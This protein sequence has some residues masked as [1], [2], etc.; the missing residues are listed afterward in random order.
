MSMGRLMSNMGSDATVNPTTGLA[1][2]RDDPTIIML[3]SRPLF[4]PLGQP[5]IP[6]AVT[7]SVLLNHRMNHG[8]H[9]AS[10][11]KFL[12]WK[13]VPSQSS[14]SHATMK[15]VCL[16]PLVLYRKAKLGDSV[17][18]LK[19]GSAWYLKEKS[20]S[21]GHSFVVS[22]RLGESGQG[23][24]NSQIRLLRFTMLDS[25][26]LPL[27]NASLSHMKL[28]CS[29]RAKYTCSAAFQNNRGTHIKVLKIN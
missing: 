1:R 4:F 12:F 2:T 15:R 25:L 9:I 8:S 28:E 11:A 14:R 3:R 18:V 20:L 16:D 24:H 22:S 7:T 6:A 26:T 19:E 13:Q 17:K 10:V 27:A 23:N 5:F 21:S 29:G